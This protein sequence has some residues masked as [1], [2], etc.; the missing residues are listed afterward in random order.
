MSKAVAVAVALSM[1]VSLPTMIEDRS[2]HELMLNIVALESWHVYGYEGY[3]AVAS[4]I[5]NRVEVERFPDSV[6][7]VISQPG[8]FSTY[9]S[10]REPYV[11]TEARRAVLDALNGKRNLPKDILFFCTVEAYNRSSFFQSLE[12]YKIEHGHVWC[13]YPKEG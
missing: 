5:M 6:E 2:E 7:G 4:V 10:T 11:T 8:Q 3:L 12:V 13:S 1:M 9:T